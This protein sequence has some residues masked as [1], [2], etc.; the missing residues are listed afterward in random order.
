MK[1]WALRMQA[2]DTLES[3]RKYLARDDY[4]DWDTKA[5]RNILAEKEAAVLDEAV[6]ELP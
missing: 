1:D 3:A 5:A 2:A 4:P 6:R